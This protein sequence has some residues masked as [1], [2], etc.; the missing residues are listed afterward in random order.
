MTGRA[1]IERKEGNRLK[2]GEKLGMTQASDKE[3]E[4][5]REMKAKKKKRGKVYILI[6]YSNN[7]FLDMS[8]AQRDGAKYSDCILFVNKG[9]T[10]KSSCLELF[11]SVL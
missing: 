7:V 6:K 10:V 9:H 3:R 4:G 11:S 8:D 1:V 5:E 2:T